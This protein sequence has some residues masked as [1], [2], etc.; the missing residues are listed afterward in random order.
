MNK[1][2]EELVKEIGFTIKNVN[3]EELICTKEGT[4]YWYTF[5]KSEEYILGF[6]NGVIIQRATRIFK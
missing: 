1:E 5:H 6:L 3:G 4:P 2:I